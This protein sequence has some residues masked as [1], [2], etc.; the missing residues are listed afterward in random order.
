VYTGTGRWSADGSFFGDTV[1]GFQDGSD[2]FDLRGSGLQ[3]TDLTIM[4]EGFPDDDYVEP[5]QI[6][7]FESFGQ[8]D[9]I[10]Q[11]DFLL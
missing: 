4:N 8:E 11:S 3:F 2:L 10:D 5:R 1:S 7:I 6:T 9:F